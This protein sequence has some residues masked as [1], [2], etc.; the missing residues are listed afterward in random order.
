MLSLKTE[1]GD[2][3]SLCTIFSPTKQQITTYETKLTNPPHSKNLKINIRSKF[4]GHH[5]D[6]IEGL[7]FSVKWCVT[8]CFQTSQRNASP[9]S[10]S[11]MRRTT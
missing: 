4:S 6:V 3:I 7:C 5:R 10:S 11:E 1:Y 8:G 2:N 9:S